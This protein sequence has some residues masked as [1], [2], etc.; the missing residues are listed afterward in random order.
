[1]PKYLFV[2]LLFLFPLKDGNREAVQPNIVFI[3]ADDMTYTAIN[4]LG[5]AEINPEA[6]PTLARSSTSSLVALP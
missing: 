4:A 2:L 6:E 1:M 5:N 3:F